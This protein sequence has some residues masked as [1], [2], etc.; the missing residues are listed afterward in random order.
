[1]AFRTVV[2]RCLVYQAIGLTSTRQESFCSTQVEISF[3]GATET[4][5]IVYEDINPEW[6][7]YIE[8]AASLP[9]KTSLTE[10]LSVRVCANMICNNIVGVDLASGRQ[11]D[12]GVY[13]WR[14]NDTCRLSPPNEVR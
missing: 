13:C 8:F 14:V 1:M 4:T 2:V 6:N 7:Q 12:P 10:E 9:Q 11:W 5:S 3:E